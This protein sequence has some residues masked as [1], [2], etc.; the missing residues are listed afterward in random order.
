VTTW[1]GSGSHVF[2]FGSRRAAEYG[3]EPAR[4]VSR[5]DRFAAVVG[6]EPA[7]GGAEVIAHRSFGAVALGGDLPRVAVA[8]RRDEDIVLARD[9]RTLL[10]QLGAW[11]AKT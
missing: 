7:D 6:A 9:E 10:A 3:S 8:R 5:R 1:F 4:L 2:T 11:G